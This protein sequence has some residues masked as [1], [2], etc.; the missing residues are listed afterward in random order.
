[1]A[2][3][4]D[5]VLIAV[6]TGRRGADGRDFALIRNSIRLAIL[7]ESHS[8]IAIIH[9]TVGIAVGFTG[10][11][12]G[13]VVAVRTAWAN[14]RNLAN[15]RYAVVLAIRT[16][17]AERW[18]LTLVGDLIA[19]AVQAC[20]IGNVLGVRDAVVVAI[21]VRERHRERI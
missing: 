21:Q 15:I 16:I 8:D 1:L 14:G 18:D 12:D 2:S 13:V 10:V 17:G 4:G 19:V 20:V 9:T 5:A 3:V 11:R 6:G 7:A